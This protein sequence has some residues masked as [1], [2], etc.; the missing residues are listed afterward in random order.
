M[1]RIILDRAVW[2]KFGDLREGAEL[3]DN[4][5]RVVGFF[6]PACDRPSCEDVETP[7]SRE[8]L[9]RRARQAGGRGL[10]EILVDLESR[11]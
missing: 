10:R 4:S 9:R 6:T 2:D 8:E 7:V 5:G 3:C 11:T 1:N